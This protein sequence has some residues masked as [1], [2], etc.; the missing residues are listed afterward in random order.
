MEPVKSYREVHVGCGMGRRYDDLIGGKVDALIWERFV[1]PYLMEIFVDAAEKGARR[2]LDFACG[3]GRIL[4]EGATIFPEVFGVDISEDMLAVARQ[5]VPQAQII[6][7]DVTRE[8]DA[9]QGNFD[10]VTLFR[11][12]LNAEAPLRREVLGWLS[13]HMQRGALLIGNLHMY[14]YSVSGLAT[15][16]ARAVSARS[17]NHDSRRQIELI[18]NEAG[19]KVKEWRG[20]R[21]LPTL[22]GQAPFGNRMQV[23]GERALTS[24]GLGRFGC[25]HLFVAVRN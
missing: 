12:L 2:Y 16:L 3:T 6:Q 13:D 14:T 8:P 23:L 1:R 20:Y 25:E 7:T 10:C 11:F 19:F 15:V 22:R 21:V 9:V 17:V 4:L 24:F 5:R 18:L